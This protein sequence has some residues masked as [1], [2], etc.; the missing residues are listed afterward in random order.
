MKFKDNSP[1]GDW[2]CFCNSFL[3][4]IF[5]DRDKRKEVEK[6][7]P[8]V[9]IPDLTLT[10]MKPAGGLPSL[11][12]LAAMVMTM[13]V[14]LHSV[15]FQGWCENGCVPWGCAWVYWMCI[16]LVV[17]RWFRGVH[18]TWLMLSFGESLLRLQLPCH[19]FSNSLGAKPT[20]SLSLQSVLTEHGAQSCHKYF[21]ESLIFLTCTGIAWGLA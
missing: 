19:P 17:L 15:Y 12:L 3:W 4:S 1:V 18:A 11:M 20:P 6:V 7:H 21:N 13:L 8:Y 5:H 2:G 9:C 16:S 10:Y 14:L